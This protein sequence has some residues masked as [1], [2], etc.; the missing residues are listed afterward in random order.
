M[1]IIQNRSVWRIL[2]PLQG[3]ANTISPGFLKSIIR[4]PCRN[5][6]HPCGYHGQRSCWK[7]RS[8]PL[9]MWR[10]SPAFPACRPLTGRLSRSIT[11]RRRSSGR[12]LTIFPGE[13]FFC[14][15]VLYKR[16]NRWYIKTIKGQPPTR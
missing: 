9:W 10:C 12:C 11:V 6:L 14:K 7:I 13:K 5:I 1:N 2:P 4:C 8:F 16:V 15:V 3:S